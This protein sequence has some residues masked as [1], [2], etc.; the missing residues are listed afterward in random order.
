MTATSAR[1][2][3]R[4]ARRAGP[5]RRGGR[6]AAAPAWA[7]ESPRIPGAGPRPPAQPARPWRPAVVF[8][9]VEALRRRGRLIHLAAERP[10]HA[11]PRPIPAPPPAALYT[12]DRQAAGQGPA[13]GAGGCRRRTSGSPG[14]AGPFASSSPPRGCVDRPRRRSRSAQ[15]ADDGPRRG[16]HGSGALSGGAWF[17]ERFIDGRE[18]N[19][20]RCSRATAAPSCCR[21]P[22]SSPWTSCRHE[23]GSSA[24]PRSGMRTSFA[25]TTRRR[26]RRLAPATGRCGER[27]GRSLAAPGDFGLAR[28][29]PG[30][31]PRRRERPPWHPGGQRQPL[32]Q[33]RC[34]LRRRGRE[35]GLSQLELVR[36]IVAAARRRA[37]GVAEIGARAA[38]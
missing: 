26:F 16:E 7:T 36:R 33:Q 30:R 11:G 5:G 28:L 15:P 17:A 24:T 19:V 8:N 23:P 12:H 6:R 29:R 20:C 10:G 31:L 14:T 2:P 22:R 38:S 9:L 37:P 13:G 34:G 25:Y 35:A 27:M 4:R 18:F 3:A 1:R 32:P 21:S